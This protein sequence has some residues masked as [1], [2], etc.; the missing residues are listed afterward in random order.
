MSTTLPE[1]PEITDEQMK[2][3][4]DLFMTKGGTFKELKGFTDGEME[5]I[6][7]VGYNLLQN[8]KSDEAEKVFR[9][10]C[11]FDHLEKKY[12]LGLG[13]CRKAQ[14]NFAGAVDAFGLA[15]ILDVKDPRAPMH[16]AECHI[17]LGNKEAALSGLYAASEFSGD[18]EKFK[19][20]K[21]RAQAMSKV[22]ETAP[23]AS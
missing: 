18:Q 4:L 2:S 19:P 3:L 16:A 15:G 5:A 8:G 9:F 17:A 13:L 6:Y 22:L 14:K 20:I 23:L 11:F 10:L 12:W 7:A 1:L 21:D